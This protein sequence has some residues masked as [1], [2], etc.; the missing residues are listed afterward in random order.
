MEILSNIQTLVKALEAGSYNAAPGTLVQGSAL[1]VENLSPVMTNVTFEDKHI[2]LQ[3]EIKVESC[4]SLL[5]QFNR[6][7]AYGQFGGSAVLEGH[8]GQ[9]ENGTWIRETVPMA[10]YSHTR[11]VT[12][13]ATMV[14]TVDGVKADEREAK[15]AAIKIA[16]D[17]EHDCFKGAADFSNAGV[18]DGN[19]L[20]I[21]NLPGMHGLDLQV[22]S[23]DNKRNTR[24]L[25]FA[26]YGANESVVISV[27][28]TLTQE[29]VE[30]ASTRS[31]IGWGSAD[32]LF[33]DPRVLSNYN[34]ITF[35]KERII[36]AGSPTD[37][38]GSSLRKQWVSQG[39]VEVKSSHFLQ[40]KQQP[41][42]P[43]SNSQAVAPTIAT[44][45]VASS[46]TA[47]VAAQVYRYYVTTQN[48][49]GESVKTATTAHTINA[50]GD[51]VTVTITH[52]G[53]GTARFFNV[54]RSLAGGAAGT[55]K[56]I[57]RVKLNEGGSTTV[58]TDLGNKIPGFVTG[59]LV[60]KPTF[61]FQ[62]LSP[63]SRIKLAQTDLTMP[64]A[65]F[66]F[67]TLCV[68]EPRKNVILDN[69]R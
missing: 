54:Y 43:R 17:I 33:V 11:R 56:F 26:E 67:V 15:N 37:A 28:G 34:K 50:N 65:H 57:G 7:L 25:M 29:A 18:F 16:A 1:Q 39:T 2:S 52:P 36:L 8:V 64:E 59:F 20:S 10:F 48:E 40:G 63:Y 62:E 13:Q 19:P 55:E 58:F 46:G 6:Q 5:A 66:R 42:A 12:L 35:G 41:R 4:K 32:E 61:M 23:S 68:T 45:N 38:T 44:A 47:F 14:A 31:S 49:L 27:G 51:A 24:D 22:R 21:P 3:K 69:L 30:D 60:E 9:E 53:S